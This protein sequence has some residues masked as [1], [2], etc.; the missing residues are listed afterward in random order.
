MGR[1]RRHAP[2][3][4]RSARFEPRPRILII[5]E[6]TVT[7]PEYFRFVSAQVRNRLVDV[8]AVG[9]G[10][11]PKQLVEIAVDRKKAAER[12]ARRSSE[13]FLRIYY[14]AGMCTAQRAA[15]CRYV[16]FNASSGEHQCYLVM[17]DC[18]AA[19]DELTAAAGV[20]YAKHSQCASY[21]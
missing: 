6:G 16:W 20:G 3:A 21:D 14:R 13:D 5:C 19:Q 15:F 12:I 4:R 8:E 10:K 11:D 1:N 9:V 7:E 18:R 17:E 2:L